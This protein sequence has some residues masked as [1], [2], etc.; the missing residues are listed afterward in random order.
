M[1]AHESFE[2]TD[3]GAHYFRGSGE[4][5][6]LV[7]VFDG[8]RAGVALCCYLHGL[9]RALVALFCTRTLFIFGFD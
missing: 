1:T 6:E 7:F 9:Y 5:G 2:E 3:E 4:S 8:C